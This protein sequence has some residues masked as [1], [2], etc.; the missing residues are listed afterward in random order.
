MAWKLS[1]HNMKDYHALSVTDINDNFTTV[2]DEVGLLN[3]HNWTQRS[4]YRVD[5][6]NVTT[7]VD[8]GTAYVIN[9]SSVEKNPNEDLEN[10]FDTQSLDPNNLGFKVPATGGW[11]HVPTQSG[12]QGEA[13][14]ITT[15]GGLLWIMASF[16][17][18]SGTNWW[19]VPQSRNPPAGEAINL[20]AV[21]AFS[22]GVEYA[23]Q[24]D[25][26]LIPESILGSG[27]N[28]V[29]DRAELR[30]PQAEIGGVEFAVGHVKGSTPGCYGE[31]LA[32][33]VEAVIPITPGTHTI[34]L[35]ARVPKSDAGEEVPLIF[36]Y[37]QFQYPGIAPDVT[38]TPLNWC[39][40]RELI[41]LELVR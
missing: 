8:P 4:F 41:V 35:M 1:I 9:Q 12:T 21:N 30:I 28:S 17:H 10:D 39:T 3:E 13:M 29:Q 26:A 18:S 37:F 19:G 16:Q 5:G 24:V 31:R 34:R 2:I 36:D 11:E 14:T 32:C 15:K 40:N 25:G 22:V 7:S 38:F 27:E 33:V 20:R 6:F 23:I